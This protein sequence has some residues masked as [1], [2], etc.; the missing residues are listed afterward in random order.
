[1]DLHSEYMEYHRER[2]QKAQDRLMADEIEARREM[3]AERH[4]A[5]ERKDLVILML[6]VALLI[7]LFAML[8]WVA[9]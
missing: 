5:A 3:L 4:K 1:M 9:R 7:G 2:Q 8:W 6:I